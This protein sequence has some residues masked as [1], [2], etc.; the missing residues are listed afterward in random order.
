MG[1]PEIILIVLF[2][3]RITIK[4][5]DYADYKSTFDGWCFWMDIMFLAIIIGLLIWGDFF[6]LG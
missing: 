6:K 5:L 4:F 3:V 2:A 1:I